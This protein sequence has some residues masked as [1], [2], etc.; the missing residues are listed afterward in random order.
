MKHVWIGLAFLLAFLT[1][2]LYAFEARK[3]REFSMWAMSQEIGFR[4][5]LIIR[6]S[7]EGPRPS[8]V[9]PATVCS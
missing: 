9:N 8:H 5:W 1:L 7:G 4:K 6:Q 3:G 2:G